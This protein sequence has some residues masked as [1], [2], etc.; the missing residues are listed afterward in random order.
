MLTNCGDHFTI[1][2]NIESLCYTL[3]TNIMFVNY[4]PQF[5][6]LL[7]SVEVLGNKIM[8]IDLIEIFF[9]RPLKKKEY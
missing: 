3:E 9:S 8:H 1:Y 7:H 5:K 2:T 4:V 6:K